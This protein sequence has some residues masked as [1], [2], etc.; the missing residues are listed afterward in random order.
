RGLTRVVML[1]LAQDGQAQ[2]VLV[3]ALCR[4]MAVT[5]CCWRRTIVWCCM[6][7]RSTH[8]RFCGSVHDAALNKQPGWALVI[9]ALRF[10]P[11]L[12]EGTD[13]V[14]HGRYPRHVN[15]SFCKHIPRRCLGMNRQACSSEDQIHHGDTEARRTA[16]QKAIGNSHRKPTP[17]QK[18]YR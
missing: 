8:P 12:A 14:T 4:P 9:L 2:S 15:A 17:R 1:V 5:S 3:N 16:R 6:T 7:C 11:V 18:P 10:L 13:P